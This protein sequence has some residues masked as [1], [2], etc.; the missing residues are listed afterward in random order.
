MSAGS[1]KDISR[2]ARFV[3]W[4]AST[5]AG[6]DAI[7]HRSFYVSKPVNRE[8]ERETTINGSIAPPY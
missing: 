5:P 6:R 4:I 1:T 8:L 7:A 2:A 3:Q